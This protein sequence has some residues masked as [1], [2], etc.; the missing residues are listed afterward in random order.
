M[1]SVDDD[2]SP[3]PNIHYIFMEETYKTLYSGDVDLL[4]MSEQPPVSAIFGVVDWC[5][6]NC[7][8]ILASKGLDVI[9]NYPNDF[10]FDAVIYDFSPGPCMLPLIHKFKYPPLISVS[11]FSNP[12]FS[13]HVTGGQKYPAFVPHYVI[14]Y[15]QIM[16]YRQRLFNHF[17]YVLDSV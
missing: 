8:G 10:K 7:D 1:V 16:T 5:V 2:E 14:N 6:A 13:N 11:A 15:P 12:V 3:G 4:E 17:L 9:L